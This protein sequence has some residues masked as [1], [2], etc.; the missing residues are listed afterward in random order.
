MIE[1]SQALP[2]RKCGF[3]SEPRLSWKWSR[4]IHLESLGS[5]ASE[6]A[7]A[8]GGQREDASG[9]GGRLCQGPET[10]P[11][12]GALGPDPEASR[13]VSR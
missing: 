5:W 2:P 4:Y 9:E 13:V 11:L 3:V 1:I 7:Q 8:G 12:L 10:G 6:D